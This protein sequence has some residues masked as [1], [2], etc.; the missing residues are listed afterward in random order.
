MTISIAILL[1]NLLFWLMWAAVEITRRR[2]GTLPEVPLSL[3]LVVIALNTLLLENHIL[4]RFGA[5][6][7]L[8]TSI[9]EFRLFVQTG[10]PELS[11][12]GAIVSGGF[13]AC[14]LTYWAVITINEHLNLAMG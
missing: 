11:L 13:G 4:F 6:A 2:R 12:A 1:T 14:V 5:F 9:Y 7:A 8:G 3:I 10:A